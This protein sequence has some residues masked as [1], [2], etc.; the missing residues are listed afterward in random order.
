MKKS[1][2]HC[3]IKKNLW[4]E[5]SLNNLRIG[6]KISFANSSNLFWDNSIFVLDKFRLLE[7]RQFSSKVL[8]TLRLT[9]QYFKSIFLSY[10]NKLS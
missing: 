3:M 5:E 10:K 4:L 8:Y 9:W 1:I 2:D 6:F 7:S